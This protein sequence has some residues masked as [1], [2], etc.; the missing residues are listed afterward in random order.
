MFDIPPFEGGKGGMLV[1]KVYNILGK[2]IETLVNEKKSLGTY[3]ITFDGNR[4]ASGVYF[5]TL[6]I[7][8]FSETKK[9]LILK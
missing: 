6:F 4:F 3:E 7:D 8:K 1:L 9:M 2:E 5:Y